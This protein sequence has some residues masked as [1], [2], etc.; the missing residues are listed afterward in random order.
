MTLKKVECTTQDAAEGLAGWQGSQ[1]EA[2]AWLPSESV[3]APSHLFPSS[4][5]REKR[6]RVSG[7]PAERDQIRQLGGAASSESPGVMSPLMSRASGGFTQGFGGRPSIPAPQKRA[8][9]FAADEEVRWPGLDPD[10]MD[11]GPPVPRSSF[12]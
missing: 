4:S 8:L 5:G 10:D 2:S 9:S 3:S 11:S 1:R 7:L 6:L 12:A